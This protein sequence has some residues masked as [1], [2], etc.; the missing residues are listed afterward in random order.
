M[1]FHM[2]TTLIIS[3]PVMR[4]IKQEAAREGRTISELV[5]AALRLFLEGRKKPPVKLKPLPTFN[6][7]KWFIDPADREA[8]Y[9]LPDED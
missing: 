6:G 4:R 5:E 7:G 8:I 2:K 3:D 1:I 9:S